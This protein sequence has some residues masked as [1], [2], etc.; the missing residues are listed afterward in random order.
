M[1]TRRQL[2]AAAGTVITATAFSGCTG[3]TDS[4]NGGSP[5]KPAADIIAGPRSDLVF[6]PDSLTVSTGEEVTWR[7]AS[8]G[9]NVSCK[10]KHSDKARLPDDAEPFASYDGDQK[11]KTD[12]QGS[13]FSHTFETP[14]RYIYVCIPHQMNGMIGEIHVEE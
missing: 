4:S 5:S 1:H 8:P 3:S 11:Y 10:A 13:T 14:G 6:D 7:F 9:H 12:P 2:L